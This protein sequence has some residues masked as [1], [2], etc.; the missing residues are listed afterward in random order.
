MVAWMKRV[1]CATKTANRRWFVPLWMGGLW[2]AASAWGAEGVNLLRNGDMAEGDER[3]AQWTLEGQKAKAAL[4]RDTESFASAPASLRLALNENG[5]AAARQRLPKNV[6]G[7]KIRFTAR[8]RR[9]GGELVQVVLMAFDKDWKGV[10]KNWQTLANLPPGDAWRDLAGE[11]E[12]PE[13][14][15]NILIQLWMKGPPGTA[16]L[17]D[18][19]VVC[20]DDP[21]PEEIAALPVALAADDPSVG[22]S[23]RWH[24]PRP[25]VLAAQ[26]PASALTVRFEGTALN[27]VFDSDS[28]QLAVA[29]RVDGGEARTL[30]LPTGRRRYVLAENLPPGEHTVRIVKRTESFAGT[31]RAEGFEISEGGRA[32]P[33]PVPTRRLEVI[34]DSISVGYGNE[35]ASKDE[36]FTPATENADIAYGA[37]AARALDADYTAIAWSGHWMALGP[38]PEKEIPT[39]YGRTLPRDKKSVWD[40]AAAPAPDAVLVN[41][42]TNDAHRGA[43]EEEG[44]VA[45]YK[46]FV[47][48]LRAHYPKARI[49]LATGPMLSGAKLKAIKGYLDRVVGELNDAN[50]TRIDFKTQD[51]KAGYGADWHPSAGQH[52]KMADQWVAALKKDL[53]W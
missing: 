17:D 32:L 25:G 30:S 51:G 45:G 19:V 40:F 31:W 21:A 33:V 35:A 36:K 14:A 11:A 24:A 9:T 2:L 16:W 20:P 1:A 38:N 28:P 4:A 39:M 22:R 6:A 49:Y 26:W 13:G 12:V 3:P 37:L 8:G 42:G 52:V 27:A 43:P 23:G 5:H 7:K 15:V 46:A 18:V 53:N 29:V 10:G 50:V 44:W 47:E 41:L 34:G 48:R